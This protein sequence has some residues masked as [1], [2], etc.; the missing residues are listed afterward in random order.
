MDQIE[1]TFIGSNI[2][3][4]NLNLIELFTIWVE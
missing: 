4:I 1:S 3:M 2:W